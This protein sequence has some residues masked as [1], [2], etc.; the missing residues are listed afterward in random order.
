MCLPVA[1]A[2][3]SFLN[4][5]EVTVLGSNL[6]AFFLTPSPS[7]TVCQFST[8]RVSSDSAMA[9]SATAMSIGLAFRERRHQRSPTRAGHM[10]HGHPTDGVSW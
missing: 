9:S 3:T 10:R 7:V 6:A 8:N 4:S 2:S 1:V 5:A